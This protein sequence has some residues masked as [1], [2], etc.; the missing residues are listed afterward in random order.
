M[1]PDNG[2]ASSLFD[3]FEAITAV[4]LDN[5]KYWRTQNEEPSQTFHGRDIF[6]PVAAHL[7]QEV[8]LNQLGSPVAIAE[9]VQLELRPHILTHN[10]LQG[11]IQHID[12]FGNVITN[13]PNYCAAHLGEYVTLGDRRLTFVTTYSDV[14]V[15]AL[16][17]LK[18]S[19]GWLEISANQSSAQDQLNLARGATITLTLHKKK[20]QP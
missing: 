3:I 6:A 18:G 12:H 14:P 15:H 2:L 8:P 20:E 4:Q 9:L 7:T 11:V 5:P 19:H 16:C 17:I 1:G 10:Q 13:I